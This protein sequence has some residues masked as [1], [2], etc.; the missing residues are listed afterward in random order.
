MRVKK[1]NDSRKE[2]EVEHA[3][4]SFAQPTNVFE[5][6]P[7][8]VGGTS[9]TFNR[10]SLMEIDLGDSVPPMS[11]QHSRKFTLEDV[12]DGYARIKCISSQ[13]KQ[14][15]DSQDSYVVQGAN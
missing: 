9:S 12:L 15:I 5:I 8:H 6:S 10:S 2:L 1:G 13:L 14:R 11:S 7:A 3:Q 4:E